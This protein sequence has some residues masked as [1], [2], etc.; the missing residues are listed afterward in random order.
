M[1]HQLWIGIDISSKWLDVATFPAT[2]A[3]RFPYTEEGLAALLAWLAGR[4]VAGIA[5]E[6]TGGI[7][8]QLAYVLANAGKPPRILNPKRVRDFAKSIT[9]AKNDRIDAAMIAR[10]A[11]IAP[12]APIARDL[13]REA[14]AEMVGLRQLLSE[15]V[16]AL[17]NHGRLLRQPSARAHIASQVKV[18][19]ARM[20]RIARDI[21]AA[22][23]ASAE[24][25]DQ[26]ALLRSMP[27][28][29]PVVSAGLLALVPE[30]GRLSAAKVAALL[31]VAPFD[32]D[33]GDRRGKRRIS[34]GRVAPRNLLYMA[35]LVASRRNPVMQAFYERLRARGK[36]AK[37]ALVAVMHKMLTRLNAM[38]HT[39]HA[40]DPDH[41]GAH[42]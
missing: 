29:G 28:V 30:L 35:A 36:P 3:R 19:R 40:W 14:L 18:L 37:V 27:G 2:E 20:Q 9:P 8:R 12:G 7:E 21:E 10:Y 32:D 26:A 42:A 31:G 33:S 16:T 4:D 22:I 23:K 38:V 39:G 17:L 34:G 6:A 1:A 5:M 41:R 13:A 24:L 25:A 15:Q 11:A